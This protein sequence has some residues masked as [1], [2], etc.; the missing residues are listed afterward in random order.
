[1][2]GINGLES[3]PV[4]DQLARAGKADM[5]AYRSRLPPVNAATPSLSIVALEGSREKE[6]RQDAASPIS[7]LEPLA[8]GAGWPLPPRRREGGDMASW[9]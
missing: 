3:T 5:R 6:S 7:W 2:N 9:E 4:D 1:M 8:D